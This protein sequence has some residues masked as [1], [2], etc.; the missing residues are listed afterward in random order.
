SDLTARASRSRSSSWPGS[1]CFESS[2][3]ASSHSKPGRERRPHWARWSKRHLKTRWGKASK[4]RDF[5]SVGGPPSRP[6]ERRDLY[7]AASAW[8]NAVAGFGRQQYR[9]LWVFGVC[10]D[11]GPYEI[12]I[13]LPLFPSRKPMRQVAPQ[14][15]TEATT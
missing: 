1:R 4:Y 11:D 3:M 14:R 6:G 8:G 15:P 9:R 2:G 13:T 12:P 5:I 10:R 7:A